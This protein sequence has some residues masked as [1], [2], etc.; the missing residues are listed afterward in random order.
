MKITWF[1]FILLY[2]SDWYT[3]QQELVLDIRNGNVIGQYFVL[4]Y[5]TFVKLRSKKNKSQKILDITK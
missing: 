3:G 1:P 4:I 5:S 2:F